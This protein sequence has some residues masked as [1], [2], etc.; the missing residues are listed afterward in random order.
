MFQELSSFYDIGF[1][2]FW[3]QENV[4]NNLFHYVEPT[5]Q[6]KGEKL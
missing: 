4:T 5:L 1:L 3:K 2:H 6:N